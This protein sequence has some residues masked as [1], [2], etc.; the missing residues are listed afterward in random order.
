M[1]KI[2]PCLW[3]N[4]DAEEAVKFY[5]SLFKNSKILATSHYGKNQPMPEGTVLTIDFQIEDQ[6]LQALN[7]GAEFKFNEAISLV[8]HCDSQA[9]IDKYWD[10][11]IAG[12]GEASVCGWL[13]D[14][15]GLSWQIVPAALAGWMQSTDPA[16]TQRVMDALLKMKKLDIKTLQSAYEHA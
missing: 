5:T 12:G 2:Q 11:L 7:G 15:Y 13:K 16:R 3:F 4:N 10:A 8:V 9:E 6:P 1:Q 14:K